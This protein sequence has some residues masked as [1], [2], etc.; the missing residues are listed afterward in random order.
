MMIKSSEMKTWLYIAAILLGGFGAACFMFAPRYSMLKPFGMV[1][2][3][4]SAYCF[5]VVGKKKA[6]VGERDVSAAA[7]K[8]SISSKKLDV[9]AKCLGLLAALAVVAS[10]LFLRNDALHG[11]HEVWPAYAFTASVLFGA[12]VWSYLF[13]KSISR[14]K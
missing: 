12:I 1:L 2:V 14:N 8:N 7:A 5:S 9:L 4:L 13:A 6:S 3:A 11:G 10:Y